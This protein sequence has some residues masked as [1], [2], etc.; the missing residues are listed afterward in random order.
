MSAESCLIL[1]T[2]Q[3][4]SRVGNLGTVLGGIIRQGLDG[5]PMLQVL[6]SHLLD[7][8]HE[9][10]R[11]M[12]ALER[13][14]SDVPLSEALIGLIVRKVM[15]KAATEGDTEASPVR[16]AHQKLMR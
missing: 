4:L 16:D 3:A 2:K 11:S 12:K 13:I 10:S 14:L 9:K 15:D 7:T 5:V 8:M 1:S 6:M